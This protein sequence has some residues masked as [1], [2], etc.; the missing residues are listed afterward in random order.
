MQK[1]VINMEELKQKIK[2]L[3]PFWLGK[4][5]RGTYQKT[6]GLIYKGSNYHCPYCKHDFEKMLSDGEDLPVISKYQ[7]IG[8]GF[9]KNC[10]CPRCYSKDRDR[11]IHLYL[12]KKTNLLTAPHR[13]LHIAPEAWLK[14]LFQSMPHIHY[15][16]GVKGADESDLD[17]T[18]LEMKDNLYDVVICNHVLEHVPEDITAMKEIFRVIKPGGWAILQVPF[19]PI[20]DNT[21]EDSTQVSLAE[22]STSFGQY[23][24]V[25][26]YG[27]DYANRL[28][29]VGFKV[30]LFNPKN[31][32]W[33]KEY[34]E[35]YALNPKEDL[36]I[37]HKPF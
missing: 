22:R 34:I 14:E 9:R 20:L 26:I 24:H 17:I 36:F 16:S 18:D 2:Q 6:L 37:V 30:E 12:E 4:K 33:G 29:S 21:F 23:D 28:E 27:K 1:E 35:K 13:V 25:R 32:N 5:I 11:L 15:T 10:T 31:E 7:I 8:G 3:I 19:S